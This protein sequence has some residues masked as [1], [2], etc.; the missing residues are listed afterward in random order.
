MLFVVVFLE[1]V[2]FCDC[3]KRTADLNGLAV[4][5]GDTVALRSRCLDDE[6]QILDSGRFAYF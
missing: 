3:F 6:L 5:T 2:L 4:C 1:V